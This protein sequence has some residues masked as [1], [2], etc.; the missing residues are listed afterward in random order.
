MQRVHLSCFDEAG[1]GYLTEEQLQAYITQLHLANI[2]NKSSQLVLR[3]CY[4]QRVH[5]SCFDEAGGG[6]LTEEQLQSYITQL[7]PELPG[8]ANLRLHFADPSVYSTIAT[9][10]FWLLHGRNGR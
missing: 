7:V 4:M 2:S 10:K 9:R 1:S 3:I 5:L 8:L 6:Y